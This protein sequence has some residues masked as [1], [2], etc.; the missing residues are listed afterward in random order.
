[1]STKCLYCGSTRIV[2]AVP[3]LDHYGDVGAFSKSAE[4]Q[5][6]GEPSAWFFRDTVVGKLVADICG[7]CGH[8]DVRVVNASELY[9]KYLSSQGP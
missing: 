9:E 8:A 4:V 2:P 7:D 3:L 1:M 5:V 6:H